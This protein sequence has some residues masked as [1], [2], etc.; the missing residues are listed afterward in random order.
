MF[1]CVV[2]LLRNRLFQLNRAGTTNGAGTDPGPQEKARRR[3]SR[4]GAIRWTRAP[5]RR[6]QVDAGAVTVAPMDLNNKAGQ[7][8]ES[9][10]E[11]SVTGHG[12]DQ[13]LGIHLHL[14][15]IDLV[16]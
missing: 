16:T 9:A 8:S 10:N 15:R 13:L 12:S 4:I 3:R 2:L 11:A 6:V 14:G 5:E 1:D 7:G